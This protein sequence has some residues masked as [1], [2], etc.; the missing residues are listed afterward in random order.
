MVLL[1]LFKRTNFRIHVLHVNFGL[2]GPEADADEAFV[3]NKSESYQ[4]PFTSVRVSTKNYAIE[5]RLSVQMAAR[6]LRY[7]WFA[8][9]LSSVDNSLLATAHHLNDSIETAILNLTRGTGIDG[10]SGIP[11]KND[12]TIRPLLCFTR[13]EIEKYAADNFIA[14]REDLSNASDHYDR[15]FIRHNIIPA[16]KKLNPALEQTMLRNFERVEGE[17]K[18][19]ESGY[20]KWL[21]E[22]VI[23][24]PD[25]WTILKKNLE[26]GVLA[27]FLSSFG[28]NFFTV[29]DICAASNGQ[30]GKRFLSGT[31]V[32]IVDREQLILSESSESPGDVVIKS[33]DHEA[34]WGNQHLIVRLSDD[35]AISSDPLVA[36]M[37]AEKVKFPLTWRRWKDGDTFVPLGMSGKK[38][39]SDFL[40]DQKISLADK[41]IQTV[42]ES[43]GRIVWVTGLRIDDEV[44]VTQS[45]RKVL[46][47][48]LT[49]DAMK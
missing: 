15:N 1:D 10:L 46:M 48:S 14:W 23:Q 38:K 6:E 12:R 25:K 45:T 13:Q 17:R 40:V 20:D 35:V 5:H 19:V 9:Q 39:V 47:M 43:D 29:R 8:E 32:L 2:R 44:K 3:R 33:N 42:I 34:F 31:H 26:P 21:H 16:L 28:F 27:R 41:S 22:S 30:S 37:D 36:T 49:R 7:H 4:V 24:F 18:L 11:V